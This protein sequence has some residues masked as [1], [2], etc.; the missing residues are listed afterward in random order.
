MSKKTSLA[1]ESPG[2]MPTSGFEYDL[3]LSHASEDTAPASIAA[4]SS[5]PAALLN[6]TVPTAKH[7]ECTKRRGTRQNGLHT[8]EVKECRFG[9]SSSFAFPYFAVPWAL[10]GFKNRNEQV[11]V[12]GEGLKLSEIETELHRELRRQS[13]VEAV[14]LEQFD[15]DQIQACLRKARPAAD[16]Q[17]I[18]SIYNLKELAQRPLLLDMIVKFLPK[19]EEGKP[20]NAANLYTVNARLWVDREEAKGCILDNDLKCAP[21]AYSDLLT[22]HAQAAHRTCASCGAARRIHRNPL[23]T[24]N[25]TLP[26]KS[27]RRTLVQ[28]VPDNGLTR[29]DL[30]PRL[31]RVFL[32]KG[33]PSKGAGHG[34]MIVMATD[35]S[36]PS[37]WTCPRNH[38]A[39]TKF[40]LAKAMSEL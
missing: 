27:N 20:I 18:Q 10:Y 9:E 36:R 34:S 37:Q 3:L 30:S 29:P 15:D 38:L 31:T 17:K 4:R 12:I 1:P 7:A 23:V 14:D 33:K 32:S 28:A 21:M 2:N 39:G 5:S 8:P 19:L 6:P 35:R 11:K 40:P 16:G 22:C 13:Y 26:P 24:P 25:L